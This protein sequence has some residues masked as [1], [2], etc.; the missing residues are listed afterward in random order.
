MTRTLLAPVIR[1]FVAVALFG[2]FA[3]LPAA[4][5]K[6]LTPMSW[7]VTGFEIGVERVWT[8]VENGVEM[9]HTRNVL[10]FITI[11][12]IPWAIQRLVRWLFVQQTIMLENAT[13]E[14]A[15]SRSASVVIGSWW[16]TAGI[17]LLIS[18]LGGIPVVITRLTL[19]FA[20]IA[21]SSTAS[22]IGDALA[23]P[24][25]VIATT[26]LYFD[27]KS[28]KEVATTPQTPPGQPEEE[29]P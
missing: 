8:S 29:I 11:I 18:L 23:L 25:V 13:P 27:L 7:S 10:F 14:E 17:W 4:G 24:F 6:T 9:V 5:G 22:A 12:G 3:I 21:V 15:L 2:T 1:L 19:V 16:R 20:P 28:R 26:M